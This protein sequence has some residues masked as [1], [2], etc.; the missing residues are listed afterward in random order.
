MPAV[1]ERVGPVAQDPRRLAGAELLERAVAYT[2]GCL[3]L[4]PGTP[5]DAHTPCEQWD[6][7]TLLRHMDDALSVFTDAAEVGY[8][9]LVPVPADGELPLL[10]ERLRQRACAL[11]AAWSVHPGTGDVTVAGQPMRSDLLAGAGSL[12]ITVHG[13]DV[14][15]ACGIDRPVPAALA[16]ELL[17]VVPVLVADADRPARFAQRVDVP[18]HARPSTRL[19]AALGRRASR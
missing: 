9:D 7:R 18:V 2:R 5:P 3:Q 11:L 10:V 6:L 4:V 17:D 1:P 19:L 16:L 12:E 14:A 8:V 15:Q 13:W